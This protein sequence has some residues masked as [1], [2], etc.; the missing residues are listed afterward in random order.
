MN[1]IIFFR[2]DDVRQTL[3]E[4]LIE[5]TNVF[6][7]NKIP[8]THAV[9]PAN[10]SKEVINW[11]NSIKKAH[12]DLIEI[13]QHGY[14]HKIKNKFQKGEFGG[15]RNYEEQYNDIKTGKELMEK[16][17]ENLWFPAFNFP[18]APYNPAAIRAVNNCGFK[19]LNSH[20]NSKFNRRIFY[21]VGNLLRKGY[22]FNHHVSW[23]LKHYPKTKLF[24]IDVNISFIKKYVDE[25]TNSVM[26]S[27]NE[28][29]KL[30]ESYKKNKVIGVLLH[31]RYHNT[32]EKIKLIN[33]YINWVKKRNYDFK[34][35]SEIYNL[36]SK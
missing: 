10:V 13:M 7:S 5:I 1:K 35:L 22:L 16:Y 17:F 32:R 26:F 20:Y 24:E 36:F 12:P 23:N 29:K 34:N 2:N 21:L 19:V 8:I 30:T 4:P 27:L 11:L 6:I 31:H 28:L 14:D 33:D 3:D 25:G 18:Y 15:Q 9:E